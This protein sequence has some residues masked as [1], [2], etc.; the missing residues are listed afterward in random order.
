MRTYNK[1]KGEEGGEVS[2]K[3]TAPPASS[4]PLVIDK[5]FQGS[6][7]TKPIERPP[8]SE[9]EQRRLFKWMLEERRK[10]KPENPLEKKQIDEEKA[11][12]KQYIRAKSIPSFW[13]LDPTWQHKHW[14]MQVSLEFAYVACGLLF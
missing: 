10:V 8:I 6:P 2:E 5:P 9:D 4:T 13:K 1:E 14:Y 3:T 12:L 11:I 7:A